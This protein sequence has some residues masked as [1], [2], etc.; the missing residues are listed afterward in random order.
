MHACSRIAFNDIS[1]TRNTPTPEIASKYHPPSLVSHTPLHCHSWPRSSPTIS[2]FILAL[3]HYNPR[4]R[5]AKQ[6]AKYPQV[7]DFVDCVCVCMCVQIAIW[8]YVSRHIQNCI[9]QQ[10]LNRLS[11]IYETNTL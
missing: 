2:S 10:N 5:D 9:T 1:C 3:F 6:I 7:V 8:C 11:Y 4:S